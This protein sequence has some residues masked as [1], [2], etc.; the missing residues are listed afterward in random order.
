MSLGDKAYFTLEEIE[1]RW[2]LP[3]R[4]IVYLAENRLL[5]LSVRLFGA[6]LEWGEFDDLHGTPDHNGPA[7]V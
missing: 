7:L 4:D 3:R 1:E 5:T 6:H 2:Q